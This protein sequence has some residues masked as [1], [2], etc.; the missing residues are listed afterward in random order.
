MPELTDDSAA[1][2]DDTSA[3]IA[4]DSCETWL[5]IDVDSDVIWLDCDVDRLLTPLAMA[6][7]AFELTTERL[8]TSDDRPVSEVA[9]ELTAPLTAPIWL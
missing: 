3:E 5:E 2:T 9:T 8:E 1:E 4:A 7:M 6:E